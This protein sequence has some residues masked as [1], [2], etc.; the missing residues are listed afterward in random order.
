V[1]MPRCAGRPARSRACRPGGLPV[2]VGDTSADQKT[3]IRHGTIVPVSTR[4]ATEAAGLPADSEDL[5]V[6][7]Q[8]AGLGYRLTR[9]RIGGKWPSGPAFRNPSPPCCSTSRPEVGQGIPTPLL[10]I[11]DGPD[12][13]VVGSRE[14]C[15]NPRVSST[16]S[17]TRHGQIQIL[18]ERRQVH[19]RTP[20][21]Q[22]EPALAPARSRLRRLRQHRPGRTRDTCGDPANLRRE[23]VGPS[24]RPYALT[25][26]S[27]RGRG[28]GAWVAMAASRLIAEPRTK[29]APVSEKCPP[30]DWWPDRGS[31]PA[32]VTASRWRRRRTCSWTTWVVTSARFPASGRADLGDR[33]P[34][35]GRH[36]GAASARSC[37]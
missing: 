35:A 32:A 13:I 1:W 33:H 21:R 23:A 25:G 30:W 20:T 11:T 22:S 2:T 26:V 14:A 28:S 4:P 3:P 19:A 12:V 36:E 16:C 31:T 15:P 29:E 8:G 18:A 7:G 24:E 34:G 37:S 6:H 17:P 10:Y 27:A 5:Q 9:G